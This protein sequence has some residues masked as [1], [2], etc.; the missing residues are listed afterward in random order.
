MGGGHVGL[1]ERRD[2]HDQVGGDNDI[3]ENKEG[4][5]PVETGHV[6]Y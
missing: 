6:Y 1:I 4:F 5:L 3:A 2:G